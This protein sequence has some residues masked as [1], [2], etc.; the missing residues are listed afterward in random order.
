MARPK[1]APIYER[2]RERERVETKKAKKK[3]KVVRLFGTSRLWQQDVGSAFLRG[4]Y[5][6]SNIV[7]SAHNTLIIICRIPKSCDLRRQH[8]HSQAKDIDDQGQERQH[9]VTALSRNESEHQ[10]RASQQQE[11]QGDRGFQRHSVQDLAQE[12]IEHHGG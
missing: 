6:K 8:D 1:G 12:R 4:V 2:E 9:P 3:K 10:G 5:L 11:S 7:N